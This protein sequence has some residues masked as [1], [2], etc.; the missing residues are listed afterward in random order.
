MAAS[1]EMPNARHSAEKR[2]SL[3][4][5]TLIGDDDELAIRTHYGRQLV[6]RG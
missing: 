2:Q 5:K 3:T 1:F 4:I 6:Y